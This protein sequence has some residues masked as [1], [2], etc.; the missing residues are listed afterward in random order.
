MT[1]VARDGDS[2]ITMRLTPVAT[3]SPVKV[4]LAQATKK[5]KLCTPGRP[6]YRGCS[7]AVEATS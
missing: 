3:L 7:G 2:K 4:G 1:E 5:T 6:V